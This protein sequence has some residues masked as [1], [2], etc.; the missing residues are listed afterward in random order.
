MG[1]ETSVEPTLISRIAA[2][3][4]R[5]PTELAEALCRKLYA[6]SAEDG[7]NDISSILEDVHEPSIRQVLDDLL[8]DWLDAE[9]RKSLREFSLIL[10]GAIGAAQAHRESHSLDLIWTGPAPPNSAFRK[11][12]QALLEVINAAKDELWVVSFASYKVPKLTEALLSAAQRGVRIQLILESK[13]E[14]EGKVT[15]SALKGL[16]RE[17]ADRAAVYVWPR[18]KRPSDPSGAQGALHAKCAVADG[19]LLFVSSANL[20]EY[21]MTLNMEMGILVKGSSLPQRTAK[22][23]K[24]LIEHGVLVKLNMP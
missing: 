1:P 13:E 20:T 7:P 17:I 22:H 23:L 6:C 12:E 24:W 11:T 16:G 2:L 10:E 3:A 15:F 18:E 9:P 21:A 4:E 19:N 8:A 14:S 5:F